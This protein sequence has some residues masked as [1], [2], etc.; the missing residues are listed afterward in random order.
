MNIIRKC[1]FFFVIACLARGQELIPNTKYTVGVIVDTAGIAHYT[2]F[3]GPTGNVLTFGPDCSMQGIAMGSDIGQIP[4]VPI[5]MSAVPTVQTICNQIT[6]NSSPAAYKDIS[7]FGTAVQGAKADTAIQ[8]LTPAACSSLSAGATPTITIGTGT[9]PTISFG[10]PAGATGLTGSQG[11]QGIQG[12]TGAQGIQ[13]VQGLTGAAGPTGSTG[14]QGIQGAT[15]STGTTGAA[16]SNGT[17]GSAGAQGPQGATGAFATR[18]FNNA[19]AR[20]IQTVAAAGNGWQLSTTR[21]ASVS[22]SVSVTT[23]TSIGGPSSGN[24]VLEICST[25]SAT[26]GN[27]TQV[28]QVVS[29]QTATLAI[30]LNLVS[31]NGGALF[32]TVPA[33]YY[34][35]LRST[36]SGGT[37]T[38]AFLSGQETLE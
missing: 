5:P 6:A 10:I 17:N 26:A 2:Y 13:G 15:G 11:S 23:T 21:D 33:G 31:I 24:I 3:P 29:S 16:G 14:A 8:S 38:F 12:A 30:A 9:T 37:V 27:W 4:L 20:T 32:C 18:S 28:G 19:P 25:N 7:F 36:V 1:I 34:A 35:R 22:Y